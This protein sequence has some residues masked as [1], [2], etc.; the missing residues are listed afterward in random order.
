MK[1]LG[2]LIDSH[3]NWSYHI[4]QLSSKLSRAIGMIARIRHYVSEGTLRSIYFGIFASLLQY[5]A[6]IFGQVDNKH[7]RRLECLQNKA[8]RLINFANY[9]ASTNQLYKESKI[10]KIAD[11]VKLQNFL[12]VLGD[13]KGQLPT[14]LSNTFTRVQNAH[15]YN[16]RGA[17]QFKMVIPAAK[18]LVYGIRSIFFQAIQIWNYF[19]SNFQNMKLHEKSKSVCKKAISNHFLDSYKIE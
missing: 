6:Q 5:G 1:Y 13:V 10:L 14:A 11:Y 9:R 16:T 2:V 19:M 18:T 15:D 17:T 3:L 8:I 7:F 12:L 4:N